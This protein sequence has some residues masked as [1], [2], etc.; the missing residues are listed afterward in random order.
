MLPLSVN[1]YANVSFLRE[2]LLVL[3]DFFFRL[4]WGMD[5]KASIKQPPHLL[6]IIWPDTAVKGRREKAGILPLLTTPWPPGHS[7]SH[8]HVQL[9]DISKCFPGKLQELFFHDHKSRT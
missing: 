6:L 4:F 8:R 2:R 1:R 3:G 7:S 5:M 9:A